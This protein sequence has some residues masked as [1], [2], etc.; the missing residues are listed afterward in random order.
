MLVSP[1]SSDLRQSANEHESDVN[2]SKDIE[3][4]S[5]SF[6]TPLEARHSLKFP[7]NKNKVK[8]VDVSNVNSNILCSN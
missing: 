5:K 6:F 1:C 8:F 7:N 2:E 3:S 4:A